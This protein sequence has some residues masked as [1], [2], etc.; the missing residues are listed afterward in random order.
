[1]K[2]VKSKGWWK[3]FCMLLV[4]VCVSAAVI[5]LIYRFDNKYLAAGAQ[6]I[7]G[8]LSITEEELDRNP[9]RFLIQDWEFY[10]N[11]LLTP[12]DF[13]GKNQKQ[14][15]QFVSIGESKVMH[16]GSGTYRLILDLPEQTN[17]Y[18]MEIPEIFSAYELYIGNELL[19]KMGEIQPDKY[20]AELQN[21]KVTFRG[22]G[23]IQLVLAVTD[24]S[25]L[26]S[27]MTY[28]PA[29]GTSEGINMLQ[30]VKL[31]TRTAAFTMAVIVLLLSLYFLL[32]IRHRMNIM[33]AIM[34]VFLVGY[35]AYPL[36]RI[37]FVMK[38]FPW[39]GIEWIC[40]YGMI[41]FVV[42][43]HN[44]ICQRKEKSAKVCLALVRGII[45]LVLLFA[46]LICVKDQEQYRGVFTMLIRGL[47]WIVAF[48]LLI[49]SVAAVR[50]EI[51][52]NQI[53]LG[54]T[55][56]FGVSLAADQLLPYFEPVYGGWFMEIGGTVQ[57]GAI[58]YIIMRNL[59]NSYRFQLAFA[60][61]TRQTE[62][63]LEMQ[64]LNYAQLKEKIE[65]T[66]GLRH[67]MRQHM[68]VLRGMLE[69]GENEELDVY[70]TQFEEAMCEE[71]VI[72]SKTPMIICDNMAVEAILQYYIQRTE[73]LNIPMEVQGGLPADL[74]M[75][76]TDICPMIGNI[77]ENA[78]EAV[79][80]QKTEG[81]RYIHLHLNVA[82][83]N[84]L[85]E[86]ENTYEGEIQKKG[87]Q[88]YSSKRNGCGIGTESVKKIAER[89]GGFV[90][91]EVGEKTF[92]AAVFIPQTL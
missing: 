89:Y 90:I 86:L 77:L 41:L 23:Y 39:Y 56:F 24:E 88:F 75:P 60:E 78:V 83:G 38:V 74:W 37:Y 25:Y 13:A 49:S 34:S 76:E 70:L 48:Y 92:R 46:V 45:L 61:R 9:V 82:K 28:P 18:A 31:F 6:P 62:Q 57:I 17:T 43:L 72:S 40:Y 29:F 91:F 64:K 27:G 32:Y 68:R 30:S 11:Q 85:I 50:S 84:W 52:Y 22:S 5:L 58:G 81:V 51:K 59:V 19:I 10:P 7:S 8:I 66:K 3:T 12:E 63:L 79:Q 73:Y 71:N 20:K 54:A 16:H 14:Y 87:E 26:Y 4:F 65:E 42:Q 69:S 1:M 35:T 67:D 33:A 44:E 55:T 80:R 21:Q 53:L 36:L 2:R 47:K 15:M